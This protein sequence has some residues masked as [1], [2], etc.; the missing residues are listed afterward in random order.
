MVCTRPSDRALH[1]QMF[2]LQNV[3]PLTGV[4]NGTIT[5]NKKIVRIYKNKMLMNI[6][7]F[8]NNEYCQALFPKLSNTLKIWIKSQL[9]E[10]I[11]YWIKRTLGKKKIKRIQLVSLVLLT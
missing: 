8:H 5:Y 9:V 10:G 4:I 11:A 7:I 3:F 1:R 6:T 2:A